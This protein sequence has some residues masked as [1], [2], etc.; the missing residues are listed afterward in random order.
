MPIQDMDRLD[1]VSWSQPSL[2]IPSRLFLGAP[3]H[4]EAVLE[5]DADTSGGLIAAITASALTTWDDVQE[6]TTACPDL[7]QLMDMVEH[8]FPRT[9]PPTS[10]NTST[11][12]TT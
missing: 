5:T 4:Q 9:C 3:I 12:G 7:Q 11:S 10:P 1:H 2:T 6:A 8:G